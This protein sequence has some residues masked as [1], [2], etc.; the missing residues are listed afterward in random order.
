LRYAICTAG[1]YY[2]MKRPPEKFGAIMSHVPMTSMIVLPFEPLWMNARKGT[3]NP[4][5]A[6]PDVTLPTV[7]GAATVQL[8]N[9]WRDRPVALVFGSYT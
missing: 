3:L 8:A 6:A 9:E 2:A 4:G 5:D 1:L 7:N